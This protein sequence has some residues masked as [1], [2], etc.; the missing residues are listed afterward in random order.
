MTFMHADVDG[1]NGLEVRYNPARVHQFESDFGSA[2]V[3]ASVRVDLAGLA[4]R[5]YLSLSITDAR[6]LLDELGK[7]LTEHDTAETDTTT[8]DAVNAGKAA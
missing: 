4:H 7:A 8:A 3:P 1:Y 6:T 5:A 2:V